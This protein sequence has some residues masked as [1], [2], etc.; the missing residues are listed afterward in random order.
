MTKSP[1]IRRSGAE[2]IAFHFC[3][4][5]SEVRDMVYQPTR[6][7]NPYVYVWGED[8]YCCPTER[9]K[10]PQGFD[11]DDTFKWESIATHYGRTVYC[12]KG[13]WDSDKAGES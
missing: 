1:Q 3:S 12:S 7:R 11:F 9:Q 10:P 4:D 8:Y 5:I 6:Y 2:I 13:S